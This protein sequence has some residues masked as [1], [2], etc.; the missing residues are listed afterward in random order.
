LFSC[1]SDDDASNNTKNPIVG[2]WQIASFIEENGEIQEASVC[3]KKGVLTINDD[4]TFSSTSYDND[5]KNEDGSDKCKLEEPNTGT[6][7]I[8][9]ENI[10]VVRNDST[11]SSTTI[12][13]FTVDSN[14]LTL[15]NDDGATVYTKK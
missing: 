8:E 2:E 9:G 10:T 4:G 12:S 15:S 7:T 11:T 1:S 14:T 5:G 6:Y 13:E 3:E